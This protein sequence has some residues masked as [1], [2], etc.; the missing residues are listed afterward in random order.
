LQLRASGT[1]RVLQ[2]LHAQTYVYDLYSEHKA[3]YF[4]I[5]QCIRVVGV[6]G[7]EWTREVQP[8]RERSKPLPRA[9]SSRA[10]TSEDSKQG[11]LTTLFFCEPTRH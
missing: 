5:G 3:L 2:S 4:Q 1:L 9:D 11:Y 7:E 6:R 8:S 10:M